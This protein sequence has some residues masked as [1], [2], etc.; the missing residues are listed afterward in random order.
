LF[1]LAEACRS[2]ASPESG[3]RATGTS[4]M[5]ARKRSAE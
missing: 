3:M 4:D 1:E 5:R 2:D